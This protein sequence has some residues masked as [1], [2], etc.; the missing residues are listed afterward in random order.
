MAAQFIIQYVMRNADL[1]HR[2]QRRDERARALGFFGLPLNTDRRYYFLV[3]ALVIV[4]TLFTKNL[5]RSRVGRAFVAIRDRYL[6]AEV[7]GINVWCAT[8]GA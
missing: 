1:A 6:S 4:A 7:M 2:R 5:T 3:Y 8:W